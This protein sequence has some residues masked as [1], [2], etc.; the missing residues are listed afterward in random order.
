MY[1]IALF[2]L[3][4]TLTDSGPGIISCAI[5][6]LEK[7]NIF[8]KDKRE[9]FPFIGPPLE[10]SFK[11]MFHL[12]DKE[13]KEAVKFYREIYK[14]TGIYGNS[15]YEGVKEMLEKL[16]QDKVKIV[17]AT[18]KPEYLAIKVLEMFDLKK[19]FTLIC[20]AIE[21]VRFKK[22]DIIDYALKSLKIVDKSEVVMVGDRKYDIIGA[23]LNGIDSIGILYG[24]YGTKEE[25]E[26]EKA[27]YIA[28]LPE[29][30]VNI[31]HSR[32]EK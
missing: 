11:T 15:V 29:D 24:G 5:R 16:Y 18:S 12:S 25:L 17:L 1:K 31:I 21:E 20:G 7:F 26:M 30:V 23:N 8:I 6:T 9:L 2:D 14:E 32:M 3:D 22:A 4:G 27:T 10:E 28:S 19:Y 13:A